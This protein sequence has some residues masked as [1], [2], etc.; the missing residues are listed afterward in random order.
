M[1]L[2]DGCASHA[3]WFRSVKIRI[4]RA[5]QEMGER[6]RSRIFIEL[7]YHITK[8]TFLHEMYKQ[9]KREH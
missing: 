6:A 3:K 4:T 5:A 8:G 7:D 1:R 2:G 9:N